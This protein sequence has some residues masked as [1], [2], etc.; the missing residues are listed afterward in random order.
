MKAFCPVAALVAL[1]VFLGAGC[2][3]VDGAGAAVASVQPGTPRLA[4]PAR[5]PRP[6]E[7]ANTA[8][9]EL[10]AVGSGRRYE[11]W[12]DV[13]ASYADGGDRRYPVV[14]VTDALYSFPLVRSIRNLLGQRGRNIE[15]FILV[16]LPPETGLTSKES[17]SRDYT[18]SNPLLEP[19]EQ[20]DSNYSATLYGEAATY[21]DFIERQVFALVA[22]EYR[23]D[24][25][26]KVFA[27]HSLG[28]LF[29]S[30]VLV[31]KPDMF[32]A[33]ILGSPSL[34]FHRRRIHD[35]EQAYASAH[36][37]LRARVRLYIGGY[38][39]RGDGARYL[40]TMDMVGDMR[41]FEHR[42]ASRGYPGL[43][44]GSEVIEG[45]DHLTVF[46]ATISRGL[47]WALP[48]TG[49]YTKG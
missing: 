26:R 1:L 13:P 5:S 22:R 15:D 34:W 32:E 29:G 7:L 2:A 8:V 18:P 43:S 38:E 39:T 33:Y 21:R 46:P 10:P 30:Y 27:G 6:L 23:A 14:F 19:R 20:R 42:L 31:T 49:P 44:I 3:Q 12:V 16:G 9:H 4:E 45:E 37:D 24:M 11:I 41:A 35:L 48:G 25:R 47:L 17:R 40:R 36:D 28:G